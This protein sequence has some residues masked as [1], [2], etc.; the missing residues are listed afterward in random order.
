MQAPSQAPQA[1]AKLAELDQA[2]QT[3]ALAFMADPMRSF[4][5]GEDPRRHQKLR[6]IF[7]TQLRY[8]S[9]RGLIDTA[10]NGAAV[11]I[12]MP[13]ERAS[14]TVIDLLLTGALK[15][16]T[17]LGWAAAWRIFELLHAIHRLHSRAFLDAE[18]H[19]HLLTLGVH[20]DFQ[21]NGLG[22][23]L[24]RAG[25]QRA[26]AAQLPCYLETTNCANVRFYESH[27]F[28]QTGRYQLSRNRLTLWGLLA[29]EG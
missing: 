20:P 14:G 17:A 6:W 10:G 19:W 27:G 23:Q 16:P 22:S 3:L 11:A 21:G 8:A 18:A 2:E 28:R 15:A 1:T 4:L 25:R 12:W 5:F 26:R 9:K 29:R 13:P 24:L 7:R